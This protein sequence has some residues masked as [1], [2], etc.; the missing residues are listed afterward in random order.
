MAGGDADYSPRFDDYPSDEYPPDWRA[1]RRKVLGRDDYTCRR[2]GIRSTRVDSIGFDVDHIVPKSDGGS[3]AL[4]NLQTLC[5]A[6]HAEKHP[7][8][9][10]LGRR[11]RRFAG[12][13][14]PSLLVRFGRAL[15]G[16]LFPSVGPDEATV[17]DDAGRR[18]RVRS[19]AE[20][21][22]L[23]EETGVTAEVTVAELWSSS[24]GSV[25]QMGRV[26]GAHDPGRSDGA[27]F[28]V[29]SGHGH[30]RVREGGTYRFVG[31]E[32]NVYDGEFQ[33]VVDGRSVIQPLE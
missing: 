5:P 15:L 9:E 29:W 19:L 25:R 13:S 22:S 4:D 28:V 33:L 16:P 2:C 10:T 30:R 17:V 18:L 14:E 27:R 1:R 3:H 12:R 21:S 8:N 26:R 32:T 31:A 7:G 20:A 24:N 23:P 6:C 11:G